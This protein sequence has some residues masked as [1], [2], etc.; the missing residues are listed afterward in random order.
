MNS[1]VWI[2][3]TNHTQTNGNEQEKVAVTSEGDTSALC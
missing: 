1:G 3:H 2:R